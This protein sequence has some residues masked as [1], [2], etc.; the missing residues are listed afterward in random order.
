MSHNRI[1]CVHA[2]LLPSTCREQCSQ[3]LAIPSSYSSSP[4]PPPPFLPRP[5]MDA[6]APRRGSDGNGA[7]ERVVNQL[8]TEM[9]GMDARTDVYIIA[10]TNRPDMIDPALLRPGRLDKLLF[11]PLPDA[12]A[13]EAILTT[14]LRRV[15]VE[16]DVDAAFVAG[17]AG[18][19]AE[20][21][22]SLAVRGSE[23]VREAAV[24]D[25]GEEEGERKVDVHGGAFTGDGMDAAALTEGHVLEP[26]KA[27]HLMAPSATSQQP[28]P[29]LVGGRQGSKLRHVPTCEGF[30]GADLAALVSA[31]QVHT[32][33]WFRWSW[34][35]WPL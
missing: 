33:L 28:Q 25:R 18:A 17:M 24:G 2:Y 1:Y 3:P 15:P 30:S 34:F 6:M 8:L 5:Q 4:I 22:A 7:A 16:G 27:R 11:I 32:S 31:Q 23:A 12:P 29:Q 19:K 26:L 9:D 21:E 35:N 20:A 10:A 14:L 13:R